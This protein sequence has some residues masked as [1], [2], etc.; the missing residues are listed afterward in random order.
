[1]A[2]NVTLS[3]LRTDIADQIDISTDAAGRYTPTLLT[4]RINQSCQRFYERLSS[5]GVTQFLVADSGTFV[6]GPTSPY[7][8]QVLDLSS[9][10]PSLVR[11]YGIDVTIGDRT[12]GLDHVPFTARNDYLGPGY[13]GEPVAWA[14]IKRDSVAILPA[15]SEAWSYLVWYL[16]VIPDLS[17]DGDNWDG[18]AGWED[19]IKWDVCLQ[20]LTRDNYAS[21]YALAE[22]QA[23]AAWKDILR[24]ATKV[25][26]A[27]G[28]HVGRD[29]FGSRM[30]GMR[31][32][33]LPRP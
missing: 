18:V 31:S 17:D 2:R 22:R 27:G 23:S 12:Y 20:L 15:P 6:V 8:F 32:R 9:L 33:S 25:S 28:A 19:Y 16:P 1:M 30:S 29:T 13:T 24:N 26:S 14:H 10:S 3:Q 7:P 11:T 5:S 21:Q 4:R